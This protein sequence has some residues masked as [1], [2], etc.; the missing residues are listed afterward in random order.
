MILFAGVP[1]SDIAVARS[2]YERLFGRPPDLVPH[3]REVAWQLAEGGWVYVVE[4]PGRA[5]GSL[6][7]LIVEDLDAEVAPVEERG[8]VAE[9]LPGGPPFKA[10]VVDPDGNR[11]TFGQ[12]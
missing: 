5:G 1:V 12:P 7:S 4:D 9:R 10:E 2:F 6:L 8:L 3:E 11:V